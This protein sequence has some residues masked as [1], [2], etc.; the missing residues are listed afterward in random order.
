[1]ARVQDVS[2]ASIRQRV[3]RDGTIAFDVRYR[4][5]GKSRTMSFKTDQSA[6]RWAN[7]VRKIGPTEALKLMQ[8]QDSGSLPT[9]DEWAERYL[10][11]R[12]GL[13]ASTLEDYRSY[14]RISISPALGHLP[15]DAITP[16]RIATWVNDL[17]GHYAGKTIA[18][19]HGFLYACL[20]SA[21]EEGLILRN[22]CGRVRLPRTEAVEKVFLTI[23]E[24]QQLLPFVPERHQLL[25]EV[26]AQTGMRWGEVSA[27]RW[28]DFDLGTGLV[29][30]SRAWHHSNEKGWYIGPPKTKMS[31]RT[32]QLPGLLIPRLEPLVRARGEWLFANPDGSP[33][34]HAKFMSNVWYPAVRLA[35]GEHPFPGRKTA[36][37]GTWDVPRA[38]VPLGKRPGLHS[39]RHS[40]ASWLIA[41]GVPMPIVQARLGHES[42]QTTIGTYTHLTP[43]VLAAPA[44]TMDRLLAGRE[45]ART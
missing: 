34:R 9:L 10:A 16:T 27:L 22:P 1:M 3:R 20:Q 45:V 14:M 17:A 43:D 23:A 18:N 25:I 2:S 13:E 11:T 31:R 12:T 6:Q 21:L 15:L 44:A 26:I 29:R 33:V 42:I 4:V 32:L 19:R 37:G 36:P 8:E 5:D 38:A 28:S 41:D 24:Y 40:H 30:V 7:I 39:L 35:N